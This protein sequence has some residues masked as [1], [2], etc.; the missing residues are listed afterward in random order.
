M[1]GYGF[2]DEV[3][4]ALGQA[5]EAAASLHHPYVGT[6]HVLLGLIASPTSVATAILAARH[7][8]PAA[9]RDRIEGTVMRGSARVGPDLPYTS[10]AKKVLE[11]AM[12]QARDLGHDYV[13]TEHLLIGCIREEKGIAAQVLAVSGLSLDDALEAFTE[14]AA[15]GRREGPLGTDRVATMPGRQ[16]AA[17]LRAMTASGAVAAVF[18]KH[19]IDVQALI[20]DLLELDSGQ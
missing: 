15:K 14:L 12:T 4:R 17:M 20:K 11:L 7:I 10:R 5:R 1:N 16:A 13:G 9:L 18:Q 19:G 8:D 6:E 2:S 3:R